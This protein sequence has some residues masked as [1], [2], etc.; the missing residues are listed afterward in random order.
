[1]HWQTTADSRQPRKRREREKRPLILTGHGLSIR[2]DKSCLLIRDGNTHYPA[3][4]REWRF[5]KGGLD[6]PPRIVLIDGSGNI[7]I[8]AL[9]WISEQRIALVRISYD[10]SN[11]IAMTPNGFAAD[12]KRVEW[13]RKTRDTPALRLQFARKLIGEK[14]KASIDTLETCFDPSDLRSKAIEAARR[15]RQELRT[16]PDISIL[17]SVEGKAALAYWRAWQSIEMKWK[18][19]SRYP[20][21]EEW[22]SYRA[23]SS[24]LSGVKH[25]NWRASHP[26]N[27]MLNYAYAALLTDV[28]IKALADGYDPMFGIVHDQRDR[29]K[30]YTPSFALDLME[31]LRPVVD[32]AVLRLLRGETFTG[33][34]FVL[35]S[36]GVCRLN[37]EL[38]RAI[39]AAATA[40][41]PVRLP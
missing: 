12:P 6:L 34:D 18:S 2:V 28:Q 15:S 13:Q 31:P 25:K 33:A 10:G 9:D 11:A 22:R 16:A 24:V 5:F 29:K 4:K 21:P 20:I 14:L 27:A 39:A 1:L 38:G 41:S 35:Q 30:A 7:S 40:V 26:I 3:G 23:R 37:P 32:R 19:Q 36:D 17:L 8:D